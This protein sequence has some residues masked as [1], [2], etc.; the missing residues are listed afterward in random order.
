MS[1]LIRDRPTA[2]QVKKLCEEIEDV[3]LRERVESL[4]CRAVRLLQISEMSRKDDADRYESLEKDHA[5][6]LTFL[7][8]VNPVMSEPQKTFQALHPCEATGAVMFFYTQAAADMFDEISCNGAGKAAKLFAA[9]HEKQD[10]E[11]VLTKQNLGK[12]L[13]AAP[14]PALIPYGA[15]PGGSFTFGAAPPA[16]G[17]ADA[18]A[19]SVEDLITLEDP[20]RHEISEL[21]ELS[22]L[23]SDDEE[24]AQDLS[25]SS[26][27][28]TTPGVDLA[29]ELRRVKAELKK[30]KDTLNLVLLHSP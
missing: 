15:A 30:T 3:N 12:A 1:G 2:E 8:A 16:V 20:S 25:S 17:T 11:L 4:G 24:E 27:D 7:K 22:E 9:Y 6:L 29:D 19:E 21:S 26:D 5:K 23:S 10:K 13:D 18:L 14:N 28:T